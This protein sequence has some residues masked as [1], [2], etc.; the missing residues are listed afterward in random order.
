MALL[1]P[2]PTEALTWPPTLAESSVRQEA[3]PN[4]GGA[5]G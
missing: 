2:K 1:I 4:V 3:A 5:S